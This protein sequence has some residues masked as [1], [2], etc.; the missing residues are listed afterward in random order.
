MEKKL[1]KSSSQGRSL[2]SRKRSEASSRASPPKKAPFSST[3][4]EYY[5]Q[6]PRESTD[7]VETKRMLHRG[8]EFEI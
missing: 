6:Q 5:Y 7:S 8:R 1:N 4:D 2:E 3:D